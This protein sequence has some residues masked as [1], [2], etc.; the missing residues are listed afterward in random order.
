M[1]AFMRLPAY[2][3]IAAALA[4][5]GGGGG[6]TDTATARASALMARSAPA[7]L[8]A[9]QDLGT[10]SYAA[11]T[12]ASGASVAVGALKNGGFALAWLVQGAPGASASVQVQ[13]FNPRGKPVG[14]VQTLGL[15]RAVADAGLAVMPDGSVV[16]A[17]V[18]LREDIPSFVEW[19]TL[20][21]ERFDRQGRAIGGARTVVV[22][23][24][25]MM[26]PDGPSGEVHVIATRDGGFALAWQNSTAQP[27]YPSHLWAQVQLFD[28]NGLSLAPA[29]VV[30]AHLMPSPA[31]SLANIEPL[32][33]G[34]V[35]VPQPFF[36]QGLQAVW[37]PLGNLTRVAMVP[38]N[39]LVTGVGLPYGGRLIPLEGGGYVTLVAAGFQF[40]DDDGVSTGAPVPVARAGRLVPLAGGGFA[41]FSSDGTVQAYDLNGQPMGQAVMGAL[42]VTGQQVLVQPLAGGSVVAVQ[43]G[44]ATFTIDLLVPTR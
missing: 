21:V 30:D 20:Y 43:P 34:G 25:S 6:G 19:R 35:L 16:V 13:S 37:Q 29:T 39:A 31:P 15:D 1:H 24:S 11:P 23:P 9:L 44:T 2:L 8:P 41:V 18:E 26:A 14:G 40:F 10:T 36:A 22:R 12:L 4:A 17:F 38:S 33:G 42:P 27:G 28:A 32:P 7:G 3:C 5:C